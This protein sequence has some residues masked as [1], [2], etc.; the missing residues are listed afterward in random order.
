MLRFDGVADRLL[1]AGFALGSGSLTVMAWIRIL[2][3]DSSTFSAVAGA[4]LGGT[5]FATRAIT[6]DRSPTLLYSPI[7]TSPNRK[8]I[9]CHDTSAVALGA[10]GATT[11]ALST[12]YHMA[13]T[14]VATGAGVFQGTW[15]C[16]LNGVKD[17]V[18]ANNFS[19]V[20]AVV[21][22]HTGTTWAIA[23]N[24]QWPTPTSGD[25]PGN[26]ELWDL[27]IYQRAL[28]A[29]EILLIYNARGHDTLV[30]SLVRRWLFNEVR[31]GVDAV[32]GDIQ[33]IS[34]LQGATPTV[35]STP[36]YFGNPASKRRKLT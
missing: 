26:M 3:F 11:L 13:G 1:T 24:E 14:F 22:P 16:Y 33:D 2:A 12:E 20:G 5:I 31:E 30:D 25:E 18:A 35:F 32:A 36:T 19:L 21:L 27:R 7:S 8:L 4:N 10:I 28:S 15:D 17:N 23:F 34:P 6:T 9:F 29:A